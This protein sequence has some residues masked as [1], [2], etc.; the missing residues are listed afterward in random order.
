MRTEHILSFQ[1]PM[2]SQSKMK[3]S[4]EVL[5]GEFSKNSMKVTQY[6]TVKKTFLC[7]Q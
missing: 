3:N 4:P 5:M 1:P 6:K 2:L 7:V